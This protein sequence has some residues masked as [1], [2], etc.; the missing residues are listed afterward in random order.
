MNSC[1]VQGYHKNVAAYEETVTADGWYRTGDV[2][3]VDET[4]RLSYVVR[5]KFNFKYKGCQVRRSS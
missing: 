1:Y 5:K 4:E 3:Y 2:F